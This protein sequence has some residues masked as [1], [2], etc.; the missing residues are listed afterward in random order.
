[1]LAIRE[2]R[3]ISASNR[4]RQTSPAASSEPAGTFLAPAQ[5]DTGL[6]ILTFNW[7]RRKLH[8]YTW[9]VELRFGLAGV[10]STVAMAYGRRIAARLIRSSKHDWNRLFLSTVNLALSALPQSMPISIRPVAGI[11]EQRREPPIHGS[12]SM[13]EYL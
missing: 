10:L 7:K 6:R 5:A 1:M 2:T 4:A 11:C 13:S 8:V 9:L 3:T 12:L